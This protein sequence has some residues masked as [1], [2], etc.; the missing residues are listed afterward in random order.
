MIEVIDILKL[1]KK[2]LPTGRAWKVPA[3]GVFEKLIKGL[4][5][6]E[7]RAYNFA[8]GTL[9]R[10]LPDNTNFTAEDATEWER[11]LGLPVQSQYLNL[12]TR[13]ALILRKYQYPGSFLN[14]QNYRYIEYQLQLA[15]FDVTVT[16]NTDPNMIVGTAFQHADDTQHGFDTEMGGISQD[17]IANCPQVNELYDVSSP[18]GVFIITGTVSPALVVTFRKLVLALK[19]VNTVAL[20]QL[21]YANTGDMAMVSGPNAYLV[22]GSN[23]VFTNYA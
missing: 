2:L 13:K 14:R 18:L 23:L 17:I 16:E 7:V 4:A 20:L 12:S 19:P 11:R 3:S 10:I 8:F 15:G 5:A 22:N 21:T 9:Y 6:S 1:T